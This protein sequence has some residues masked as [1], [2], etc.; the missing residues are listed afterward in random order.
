V[1]YIST[2]FQEKEKQ[3]LNLYSQKRYGEALAT[4]N[5]LLRNN[6]GKEGILYYYAY[7][8]QNLMGDREEAL[9][10]MEEAVQNGYWADPKQ[11]QEEPDLQSL[12]GDAR[13]KAV[14]KKN[15]DL[16]EECRIKSKPVLKILEPS[17]YNPGSSQPLPLI[18]ALHGNNQSA[19]DAI[20]EWKFMADKG[21]LVATPQSSQEVLS[22]AYV[23]N[24]FMISIPE[25]KAHLEYIHEKYSIDDEKSIIAGFSM[26]GALAAKLCLGQI[27]PFKKFILMGPYLDNPSELETP[28][29]TFSSEKGRGYLIVGENDSECLEGTKQLYRMLEG[30]G[31]GCRIDIIPGIAH[32]YPENFQQ[33]VERNLEFLLG[34]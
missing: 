11:L 33:L 14:V 10:L 3:I 28:V 21:W 29:Q 34:K 31:I 1:P 20:E 6:P 24:D 4:A 27:I 22:G 23:W 7:C 16:A 9:A 15:S 19:E 12:R 32:E 25:I 26:G 2:E 17:D 8:I 30:N 13:F 5:E 18:I